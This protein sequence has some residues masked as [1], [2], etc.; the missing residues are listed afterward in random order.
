[1]FNRRGVFY[2][3]L[4]ITVL[5][6]HV[7]RHSLFKKIICYDFGHAEWHGGSELP[8]QGPNAW[9]LRGEAQRAN[10]W[11]AGAVPDMP[12]MFVMVCFQL[13]RQHGVTMPYVHI[14]VY[15]S[16]SNEGS[17]PPIRSAGRPKQ[18]CHDLGAYS[19]D[20]VSVRKVT[21]CRM[22]GREVGPWGDRDSC[23]VHPGVGGGRVG[24]APPQGS[25]LGPP[26]SAPDA[27]RSPEG[28]A[29]KARIVGGGSS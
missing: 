18:M 5:S 16:C 27:V 22:D 4:L 11:A 9:P 20:E 29:L 28:P 23:A 8:K 12:P 6:S 26:G 21:V 2:F 1:M 13:S 10:H 7:I 25:G 24:A 14:F 19:I 3:F 17:I 15:L